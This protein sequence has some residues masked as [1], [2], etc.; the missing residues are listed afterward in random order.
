MNVFPRISLGFCTLL[1]LLASAADGRAES[2]G[3]NHAKGIAGGALLGAEAVMIT[4]AAL[5]VKPGWLYL[6]GGVVG[7][8]GGGWAGYHIGGSSSPKPPSFL[9]AGGIALVIPTVIG[10]VTATQYQPPDSYRQDPSPAED[11]PMDT[12][13]ELPSVEVAR[14]FSDEEVH[15][16][17]LP[18]TTTVHLSLL[19]GVF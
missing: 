5:G 4:E 18:R 12:R 14:S 7:G 3:T 1:T 17:R 11:A 6:L 19:R 10:V 15:V 2:S 16:F 13:L 8:A 9:I